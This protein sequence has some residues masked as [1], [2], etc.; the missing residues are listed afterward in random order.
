M[1][2]V[3]PLQQEPSLLFCRAGHPLIKQAKQLTPAQL[4]EYPLASFRLPGVIEQL[5]QDTFPRDTP[6]ISLECD[7]LDVLKRLVM[8]CDALSFA[9]HSTL[10]AELARGELVLLDW[11]KL[12]PGTSFGLVTRLQRP[13]SPAAIAFIAMLKA[14]AVSPAP[15]AH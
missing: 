7:N 15:V 6:L 3:E 9:S 1:L 14:A 8:N 2:Q 13:L 11:P 5:L 10:A 12:M 4:A